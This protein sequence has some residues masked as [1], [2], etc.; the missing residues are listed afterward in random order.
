M[1]LILFL[2]LVFVLCQIFCLKG[3]GMIC[4]LCNHGRV[5][6]HLEVLVGGRGMLFWMI[7]RLF[8]SLLD[9]VCVCNI[10]RFRYPFVLNIVLLLHSWHGYRFRS[11]HWCGCILCSDC[12]WF[13]VR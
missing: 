10:C 6:S 13:V 2:A 1:Y 11:S 7:S 12:E 9:S 3:G 4:K 8:M 5:V